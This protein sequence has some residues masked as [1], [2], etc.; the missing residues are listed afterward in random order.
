[1]GIRLGW[2]SGFDSGETLDYVYQN[3]PRGSLVVGKWLD[4]L[5]LN[6]PGWR[7]I[8]ERKKNLLAF[9][10]SSIDQLKLGNRPVRILDI[11]A[12]CGRYILEVMN[13]MDDPQISALL[14]DYKSDNVEAGRRLAQEMGT[15]GA[16]F[17][18]GDAFDEQ[19]LASVDPP[20]TLAVV[21]GLYELIPD[22]S[23]VLRSLRGLAHALQ[24]GG[25]LIYTGQPWHPELEMIARV[26]R[27]REGNDWVMRRRTQQEIDEL[28]RSAGFTKIDMAIDNDGIFTVSVAKIGRL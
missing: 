21:S 9:L 14:R 22:N 6:S 27:N 17:E 7:G 12:G 28:V 10:R 20:P 1:M 26:L 24:N 19:S 4:R 15:G 16:H 2:R 8:R 11:A 18:M 23:K 13:E 25:Y 5:Y 3:R